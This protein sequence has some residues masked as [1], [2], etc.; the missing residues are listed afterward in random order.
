MTIFEA[1]RESHEIQ[2]NLVKRV[3]ETSGDSTERHKLFKELKEELSAHELAEDRHFYAPMMGT[4]VGISL[5]RHGIAEHHEIDEM[6]EE[7]EK[8]DPSSPSW[9][10]QAKKLSEKVHH[11]LEE[12][13]HGF[14]Q[15]AGKVL[16]EKQK[17][18]LA[19]KYRSDYSKAKHAD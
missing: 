8:T 19:T 5:S 16:D 12:E 17:T 15:T 6:I 18:S 1:L 3:L 13:E 14:F 9:I 2:R 4:D 11:H 7:L 10:A